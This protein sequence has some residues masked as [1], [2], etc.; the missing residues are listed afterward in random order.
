M[1][2]AGTGPFAL[3]FAALALAAC[4]PR[5]FDSTPPEFTPPPT[6]AAGTIGDGRLLELTEWARDT[7]DAPAL[8]VIVI[9]HGQV[10]ERAVA[11]FRS[12]NSTARATVDDKWHVGAL[13]KTLTSTLAAMLVEDGLITWDTK[14]LDVWPELDAG[15]DPAFRNITLRH[16]LSHTSG[17]KRDDNW[18]GAEDTAPGTLVEKRRAWA[19]RLLSQTP[20]N[21]VDIWS[22]SNV[23][24]VVAGA[25][26]ETRAQSQWETMLSTRVF[27]PLGMTQS[28]FGAPG[29]RGLVDQP[30]GHDTF[31]SHYEAVQPG[32]G[33]DVVQALG[34]AGTVHV[35][36]DDF[37]RFLQ[38]HMSGEAGTPGILSVASFRTLHTVVAPS[39]GYALGWQRIEQLA[40]FGLPAYGHNG[41]DQRWFSVAWFSPD[42]DVG[43]V[44]VT[45]CG[46][47]HGQGAMSALDLKMRARFLAT[48]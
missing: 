17:M 35:S 9:R 26:L 18:E 29:T 6:P 48:P 22:Y 16:L 2:C 32:P 11:G 37:A 27:A 41:T 39:Q 30:L 14:P 40:S 25:M 13:T 15:M 12:V 31:P 7:T 20:A 10:A 36:L 42:K 46:G 19:A 47:D 28:G 8:G 1:R 34:P 4:E 44:I 38:A 3:A 23:G 5:T 45:N 33:S 21:A 43:L 24:Y